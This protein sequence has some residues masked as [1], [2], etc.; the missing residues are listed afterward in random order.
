MTGDKKEDENS[1]QLSF[2]GAR[3]LA[4]G[5]S[6]VSGPRQSGQQSIARGSVVVTAWGLSLLVVAESSSLA[7]SSRCR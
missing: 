2:H 3:P 7:F 5:P 1:R 6:R 4:I